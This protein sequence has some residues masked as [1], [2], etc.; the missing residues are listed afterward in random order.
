M[1][2]V[3]HASMYVYMP[4]GVQTY[5]LYSVLRTY[6]R[7]VIVRPMIFWRLALGTSLAPWVSFHVWVGKHRRK[8]KTK[9][10][11]SSRKTSKSFL[12]WEG[13]RGLEEWGLRFNPLIL[14]F[15]RGGI[16]FLLGKRKKGTDPLSLSQ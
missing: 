11:R 1:Y 10:G 16:L 14:F 8:G 6:I 7:F 12:G 3:H 13:E 2:G 4:C 15:F 5:I 9:R